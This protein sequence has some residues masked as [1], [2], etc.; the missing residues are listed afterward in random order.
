MA[1][2]AFEP[3]FDPISSD[4]PGGV[5]LELDGDVE[6]MRFQAQIEG[7][8]PQSFL[9]FDRKEAALSG[10][11]AKAGSLLKRSADLRLAC[12][13]AKLAI[14]DGDLHGFSVCLTG[15]AGWVSE[16]WPEL[17]PSLID[18][19]P[20][21]R[22]ID[23]KS[24]DDNPHTV[25]PLQAAPLFKS[26]RLGAVSLRSYLLADGTVKPRS[27]FDDDD[28]AERVPT[29]GDL[30]SAIKEADLADVMAV[31]KSAHQLEV[32]VAALEAA[33]DAQTGDPGAFRL[34]ALAATVKQL[35]SAVDKA[36]VSKDPS[37]AAAIQTEADSDAPDEGEE[38]A[39]SGSAGV[40]TSAQSMLE[41]LKAAA[42]Y[43][44][45]H[46][47]SSPVRLLL[48]QAEALIGKSFFDALS[49]LAPEM[50]GQASIRPARGLALTLPLERL[51]Q[52]LSE[53][54]GD[55]ADSH[56]QYGWVSDDVAGETASDASQENMD[57]DG[58][59]SNGEEGW[60]SEDGE[61]EAASDRSQEDADDDSADDKHE[62]VDAPAKPR[63]VA[64]TRKDALALLDNVSAFLRQKEPSSPIPFIL[65][66]VK[67]M[68]GRDFVALLREL[69][70]ATMLNVD[71]Q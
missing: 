41:A 21:L 19:D 23:L 69:L 31:H 14:L 1:G 27:G 60:V 7:V 61:D 20:V 24:L 12:A 28:N 62:A 65:D 44:A 32:A 64:G 16:R 39:T 9:S 33:V 68:A 56:G 58:A 42:A 8:L 10:H 47:P 34:P 53:T 63:I 52:L 35:V 6:F 3:L 37:L 50:A 43:F 30:T 51:A 66:H 15:I 25:L 38:N 11:I 2:H 4:N 54:N 49:A 18:G 17:Y 46:E 13:L 22:L 55:M 70:P 29:A 48:V 45:R 5:D 67:S 71:D 59:A 36:A 26:R 40:V 57:D